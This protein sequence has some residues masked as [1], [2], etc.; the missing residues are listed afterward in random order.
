[1]A[2]Y[3]QNTKTGKKSKKTPNN[4][5]THHSQSMCSSILSIMGYDMPVNKTH[6]SHQH[7]YYKWSIIPLDFLKFTKIHVKTGMG[8]QERVRHGAS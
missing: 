8:I 7:K 4:P 1:M 5:W 2:Q 6:R 3:G